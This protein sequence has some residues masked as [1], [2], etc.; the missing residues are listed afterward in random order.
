MRAFTRY[1]WGVLG[2][3]LLVVMWGAFVR[4][5]GSGAGCGNH[6][7]LCNGEVIPRA[8]AIETAIELAHRLT[9]ALALLLVVGLVAAARRGFPPGHPARRAA[10]ASLALLVVEALVG[11]GL[12]LFGW[13][14]QDA[15]F[16]RGWVMGLHL[17]NTFLLLAALALTAAW[18]ERP[19]GLELAGRAPLA[20]AA[21]VAGAALLVT[22]V[23]G[24]VAALGDTLFPAVSFAEGLRQ[25]RAAGSHVLLRLRVLHPFA[26]IAASAALI[27]L[28]RLALRLRAEERVRRAAL[29]LVALV[30]VQMLV[31]LVNVALLAPVAVQILHLLLADL[32]WIAFVLLAAAALAP[33]SAEA[34]S[35]ARPLAPAAQ[36]S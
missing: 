36:G 32:V 2:Y 27:A 1:A 12:V 16:A 7:P 10:W 21:S 31:G 28:A 23:T 34:R 4:A 25:D 14:A 22:G 18:A 26:A 33:G 13:V 20:L 19:G 8:G 5:T 3:H 30:A 29:A 17:A 11:A 35:P 6:W 24:A 9:S 15:S